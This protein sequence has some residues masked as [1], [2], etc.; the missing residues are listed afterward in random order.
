MPDYPKSA[1]TAKRLIDNSGRLVTF[2]KT[3][4]TPA[5]PAKP[6]AGVS[7]S[8]TTLSMICT[9]IEYESAEINGD[10][11]KAGDKK[12]LA[13]ALDTN[14]ATLE[15]FEFVTD[16]IITWRI[17]NVKPLQPGSVIIMYEVQIRK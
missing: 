1:K 7:G 12:L 13:N 11:I 14:G 3:S 16:G 5:D 9:F 10:A 4:T 17:K 6:W 8:E 15:D 2:S